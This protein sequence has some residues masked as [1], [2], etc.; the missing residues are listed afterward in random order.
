MNRQIALVPSPQDLYKIAHHISKLEQKQADQSKKEKEQLEE[1]IKVFFSKAL[2]DSKGII[3][4]EMLMVADNLYGPGMSNII[5]SSLG[6]GTGELRKLLSRTTTKSCRQ[7]QKPFMVVEQRVVHGYSENDETLCPA[8]LKLQYDIYEKEKQIATDY[9]VRILE[10]DNQLL[11]FNDDDLIESPDF[12][13]LINNFASK[14]IMT[15][16]RAY[17][18][19]F[20]YRGG[21]MLCCTEPVRVYVKDLN[22]LTPT[23]KSIWDY[24]EHCRIE[25]HQE[26]DIPYPPLMKNSQFLLRFGPDMY[27]DTMLYYPILKYPLIILCKNCAKNNAKK[28]L[29]VLSIDITRS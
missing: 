24:W 3:T 11:H 16:Y 28:F 15:N 22:L 12:L 13:N 6:V 29:D 2:E 9:S 8:C 23:I 5:A 21:C 27:F 25:V 10:F 1:L 20:T 19:N 26:P 7:C 17:I 18:D 4:D 14:W